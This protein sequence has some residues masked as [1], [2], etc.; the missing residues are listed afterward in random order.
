MDMLLQSLD[1]PIIVV[2]ILASFFSISLV[3]SLSLSKKLSQQKRETEIALNAIADDVR[4]LFD[5]G[6]GV[7]RKLDKMAARLRSVGEKQEHLSLHEPGEQAY[8][9]AISLLNS[10]VSV[11]DVASRSGLSKAEVDLLQHLKQAG[12]HNKTPDASGA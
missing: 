12:K 3:M 9:A 4:V 7:E 8:R 11:R 5:T 10:G 2:A 1:I 6:A